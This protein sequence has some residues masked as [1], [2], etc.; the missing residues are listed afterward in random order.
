MTYNTRSSISRSMIRTDYLH[1]LKTTFLNSFKSEIKID[2]ST[3][4]RIKSIPG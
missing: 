3:Q 2:N 1:A 4:R